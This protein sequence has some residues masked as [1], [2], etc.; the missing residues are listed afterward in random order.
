MNEES[1]SDQLITPS[2]NGNKSTHKWYM[3][4]GLNSIHDNKSTHSKWY[5]RP[6]LS[7]AHNNQP[8]HNKWYR[9]PGLSPVNENDSAHDSYLKPDVSPHQI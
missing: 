3:R 9:N 7:P 4:P 5:L 1:K 2:V 8:T 6:D